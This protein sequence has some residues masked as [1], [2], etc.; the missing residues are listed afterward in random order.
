MKKLV[1]AAL[2]VMGAVA[3]ATTT[4]SAVTTRQ[5][6]DQKAE[7]KVTWK[8]NPITT[9]KTGAYGE[10]ETKTEGN[11]DFEGTNNLEQHQRQEILGDNIV[12]KEE[13]RGGRTHLPVNTAM[14]TKTAAAAMGISLVGGLAYVAKRKIV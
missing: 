5:E 7:Q 1:I 12:L 11:C 2:F 6:Q 13:G 9:T 8:C 14:D 3:L 4:A 10:S